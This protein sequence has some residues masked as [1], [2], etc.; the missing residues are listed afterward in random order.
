MKHI[1]N[2]LVLTIAI[3][4]FPTIN[5][6]AQG[7][8]NSRNV[9]SQTIERKVFKELIKLNYYGVFDNLKYKV[10]GNTVT[11]YGKVV[12]PITKKSAERVTR[13]INGVGNVIN[14]IEVLP[15]SSFD[16]SI[17][18]RTLRTFSNDG[19]SLYRYFL[20]NNPSVRIIVDGGHVE[21]EGYVANRGDY[22]L[23]NILANGVPGVF[24]VRNNLVVEKTVR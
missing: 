6:S 2:L 9:S 15:L 21:L 14:K 19:G 16:D 24:S 20:G 3:L 23:L 4:G 8:T 5:V 22:N 11:L 13:R 17:R 10:D 12:Q 18:L 7:Y 1:R